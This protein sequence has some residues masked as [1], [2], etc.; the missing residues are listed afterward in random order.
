M[1]KKII[2]GSSTPRSGGTLM[3]NIISLHPNVLITKDIIHY[4]RYMYKK[5]NLV[6]KKKN[7]SKLFYEFCLRVKYRNKIE[8]N[9]EILINKFK[10]LKRKNYNGI[11]KS[12]SEYFLDLNVNKKII[13]EN[14]N[15]EWH[16]IKDF[17]L[18][19]K[20]YKAFQV[21]RDPRA[22]LMSWKTLTYEPGYRYLV[23]L[24]Y[25]LDAIIH[26]E[27]NLSKFGKKRFIKIRFE[28]IHHEPIFTI[29]KIYKFLNLRFNIK[30]LE[31]KNWN[32]QLLSKFNYINTTA[33]T[34]KKAIGFSKERTTN[35]KKKIKPWEIAITQHILNEFMVKNDYDI[36][37]VD[38]KEL[39]KGLKHIKE[40][41]I[42]NKH[43]LKFKKYGKGTHERL[44]DP[45]KPENWSATD[46]SKNIRLKFKDTNE[47]KNY[48]NELKKIKQLVNKI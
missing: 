31:K 8:L 40:D 37:K 47:F 38:Q 2:F 6:S 45:A 18:L 20:S 16:N 5:Y 39:K 44:S 33:Y 41:K 23:I 19:D 34:N 48:M 43:Y 26:C 42:L 4:F 36:I 7:Y 25:W 21:I 27:K 46:T 35:W 3:T 15:S 30:L 10:K 22:V 32:N 28:D 1:K 13:G 24:F 17:L 29:K 14:A 9:P 12:V 11:L